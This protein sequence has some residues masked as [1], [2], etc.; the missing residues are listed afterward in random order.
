VKDVLQEAGIPAVHGGFLPKGIELGKTK[1]AI[2]TLLN[3]ASNR[4]KS[5]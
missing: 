4:G 5:Q 2:S 3:A 1:R